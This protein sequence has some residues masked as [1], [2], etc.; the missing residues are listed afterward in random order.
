MFIRTFKCFPKIFIGFVVIFV[1]LYLST[2]NNPGTKPTES[3]EGIEYSLN[4]TRRN[5]ASSFSSLDVFKNLF[6][7]HMEPNWTVLC[8]VNDLVPIIFVKSAIS[9]FQSRNAVRNTWQKIASK[10]LVP[11]VFI[12]GH[13]LSNN[14]SD[15]MSKYLQLETQQYADILAPNFSDIYDHM[16]FKTLAALSWYQD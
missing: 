13:M 15:S 10:S 3:T 5:N 9:E 7:F 12:V 4:R 16:P 1:V 14:N 2:S 6:Q 11:V 8:T